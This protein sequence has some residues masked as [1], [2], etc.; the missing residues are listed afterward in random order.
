QVIH[1]PI[2]AAKA[3]LH[4]KDTTRIISPQLRDKLTFLVE[5]I[6]FWTDL[7]SALLP[8]MAELCE[9][10]AA[11]GDDSSADA[12][13][14]QLLPSTAFDVESAL[15]SEEAQAP[16]DTPVPAGLLALRA[17]LVQSFALMEAF[18]ELNEQTAAGSGARRSRNY[19]NALSALLSLVPNITSLTGEAASLANFYFGFF[20]DT[21][22][23]FSLV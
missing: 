16:Q 12:S 3:L 6:Q 23:L 5:E 18:S 19:D 2:A 10:D 1:D 8:S 15:G 21:A 20:M 13:P 17:R 11:S 7:Q 4:M 14:P 22:L 9:D